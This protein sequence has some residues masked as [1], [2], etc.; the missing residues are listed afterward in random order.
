V[1][2][3]SISAVVR[4]RR[5]VLGAAALVVASALSAGAGGA[6][7][8][9]RSASAAPVR[10]AYLSYAVA[11]SYDAPMLAAAKA[12]ARAKGA[13]VTV[14]DAANDPKKQLSELQTAASSKQYDAIIVQPIF[15]PQLTSAIQSAIKSGI[16][17]VN[18]DQNL[19][20]NPAS[21]APPI[22]GL[23]GNVI[24]VQN[25][26][27]QRQ[28]ALVVKACAEL[29]ASPCKVGYLYS[30]KVSSL[31]TAIRK[32]F[33]AATAGHNVE[34]VAEGETFYNPANALKAAQTM[35]QAHS[36]INVIVGA[37]QGATGAQQ[38]LNGQKVTLIGYGGGGVGLKAVGSGAWYGTV[39]QRPST[40]GRLAMACAIKAVKTGK[41]CGGIDVLKGLPDDG[42]VTQA[43]AS[44]FKAEW[45]G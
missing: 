37:D 31:D 4:Q 43:N 28:G 39:V 3:N 10:V 35:L 40:E 1:Q 25:E 9:R 16:K 33:D 34:V 36:D 30:V 21:V 45:P 41:G 15:G 42:V 29:N 7:G 38:A 12:V 14:F 32:A 6:A 23:S 44:K 27:G 24:F 26:I 11:N 19:G 8:A 2:V 18:M 5:V 20:T 13:R 17:V 22:K